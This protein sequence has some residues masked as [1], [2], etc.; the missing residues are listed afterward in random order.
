VKFQRQELLVLKVQAF[1]V[2]TTDCTD[3]HGWESPLSI[4][5]PP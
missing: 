3:D 2:F 5:Q 4:H 1:G